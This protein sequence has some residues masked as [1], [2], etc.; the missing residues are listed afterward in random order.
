VN[1]AELTVDAIAAPAVPPIITAAT[2]KPAIRRDERTLPME[3][4][5]LP[6]N[7][8]GADLAVRK[9]PAAQVRS[10]RAGLRDS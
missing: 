2:T 1:L 6:Q 10:C 5:P 3:R 8:L 7:V 9:Q 4:I